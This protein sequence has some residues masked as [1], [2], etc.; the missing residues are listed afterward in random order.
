MAL[1]LEIMAADNPVI[2]HT[3]FKLSNTSILSKE[4]EEPNRNLRELTLRLVTA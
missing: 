4:G 1:R 3:R 2:F